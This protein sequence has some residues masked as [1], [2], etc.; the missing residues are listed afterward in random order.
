MDWPCRLSLET[1]AQLLQLEGE[2]PE[3]NADHRS[4][5][6]PLSTQDKMLPGTYKIYFIMTVFCY[7]PNQ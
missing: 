7:F 2:A 6:Y 5:C 4:P 1:E 3:E